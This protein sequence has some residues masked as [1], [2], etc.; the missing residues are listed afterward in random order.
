MINKALLFINFHHL[1]QKHIQHNLFLS[2]SLNE[3]SLGKK[4]LIFERHRN[5]VYHNHYQFCNKRTFHYGN[6]IQIN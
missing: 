3:L 6:I 5:N 1:H 2:F 4:V